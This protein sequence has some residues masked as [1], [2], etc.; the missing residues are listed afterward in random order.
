VNTAYGWNII[1]EELDEEE[2][3]LCLDFITL[4]VS[5]DLTTQL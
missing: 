5:H 1:M 3:L 4:S 2:E